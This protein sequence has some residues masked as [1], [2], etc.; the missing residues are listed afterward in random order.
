MKM[1]SWIRWLSLP[2][3]KPDPEIE[4]E[5]RELR[6]DLAKHAV[7]FERKRQSVHSIARD[8]IDSMHRRQP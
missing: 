8:A 7:Q 4:K 1:P 2:E 5:K 6:A 3:I